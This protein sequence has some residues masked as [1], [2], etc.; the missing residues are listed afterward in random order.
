MS[1]TPHTTNLPTQPASYAWEATDEAVAARYGLPLEAVERFDL[2]TPGEPPAWLP[3]A[4]ARLR[5]QAPLN[6]YPPGDYGVLGE[7]AAAVH[8][9]PPDR[10]V[11]AAGADEVLDICLKAFLPPGGTALIPT[12][13][14]AMYRVLVEQRPAVVAAIPRLGPAEGRLVDVDAVRAAAENVALIHLCDPNNP[15]AVPEPPGRLAALLDGIAAD[16]AAAGREAPVV[17]LDEAYAEFVGRTSIP[18]VDR[19]PRLVVVRTMSKAYALA[20]FRVG[21]AIVGPALADRLRL[22]RAPGSISTVSA[23]VA[24]EALLRPDEMRERVARTVAE[25]ERLSAGLAAAGWAAGESVTN[26]LLVDFGGADRAAAAAEALLSRGLV[27]RTFGEG[28]PL[29]DHLRLTVRSPVAN[30][31]LVEAARAFGRSRA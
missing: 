2:N 28:H 25:R 20:S 5:Y 29:A 7:T 9:V 11:V 16:A 23:T 15:T 22:F 13:T 6:D 19:Y 31:R 24:T 27:P 21:F 14:Y 12:P 30:D 1:P 8:G 26:F 4:L 17:V 10:V 3:D 18:L